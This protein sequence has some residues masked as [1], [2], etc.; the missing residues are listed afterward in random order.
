MSGS[1]TLRLNDREQEVTAGDFIAKPGGRMLAH[2]FYNSGTEPML[3]L[4]IG[5]VEKEDTCYYPDEDVY[6]HKSN[7]DSR[8]FSGDILLTEWTS[9]PNQ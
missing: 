1:G 7:G 4:D 8:A 5:T 9:E 2:T 3:I 6:L